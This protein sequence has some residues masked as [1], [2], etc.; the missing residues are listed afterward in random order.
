MP[1]LEDRL[2]HDLEVITGALWDDL[3]GRVVAWSRGLTMTY[4]PGLAAAASLIVTYSGTSERRMCV[5]LGPE[6]RLV[7]EEV[8][9]APR[10]DREQHREERAAFRR[11]PVLGSWRTA[12]QQGAFDDALILEPLK[13]LREQLGRYARRRLAELVEAAATDEAGRG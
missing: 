11:Q 12:V 7:G 13:A 9:E 3:L 1:D 6:F 2:A 10:A 8:L 5:E 4:L